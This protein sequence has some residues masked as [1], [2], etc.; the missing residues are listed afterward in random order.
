MAGRHVGSVE[1]D[2]EH[3]VLL[4]ESGKVIGTALKAEV[5]TT[6]TPLH[7]AFSCYV[8]GSDG[9]VLLTQ[10]APAKRTWPGV[11]TNACCGHPGLDED[12]VGAVLRRL[13]HELGIRGEVEVTPLLPDFRYRAVMDNGIVENEICP[14]FLAHVPA[15]VT[16]T[17][18]PSEVADHRWVTPAEFR[19]LIAAGD[20]PVSPWAVLQMQRLPDDDW[21]SAADSPTP[22]GAPPPTS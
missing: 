4:D 15:G 21:S 20:V 17:P 16:V 13:T 12:L 1:P 2:H 14:V 11:W 7:L 9:R 22:T 18:D 3:V 8:V 5:H 10:R 19:A 6:D